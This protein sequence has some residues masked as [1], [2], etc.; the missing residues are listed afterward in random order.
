MAGSPTL[1]ERTK[2]LLR[3]ILAMGQ[4]RLEMIGLAVEQEVAALG[5]E[6]RLA[7]VCIISAWLAGT[8]L[9][10]W[11]AVMFPREV[12]LW[13]LGILCV[14]FTFTSLM[15]WQVLKR[16]S[17]RERLFTRLAEQLRKD[18]RALEEFAEGEHD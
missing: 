8:S 6:L 4:T 14:L 18:A 2:S 5:R 3:Q 11:I 12:G 7:A 15:T 17:I 13:I 9:V 16:V 1:A 10:L